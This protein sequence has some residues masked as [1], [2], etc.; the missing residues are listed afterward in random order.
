MPQLASLVLR[1]RK[2]LASSSPYEGTYAKH[3]RNHN[4]L[5][6]TEN[7]SVLG[8]LEKNVMSRYNVFTALYKAFNVKERFLCCD[9]DENV[10]VLRR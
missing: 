4:D 6:E 7:Y 10:A 1:L 5:Q 2:F 3:A 9:V 8:L